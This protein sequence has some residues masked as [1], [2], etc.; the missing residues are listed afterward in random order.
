MRS[1]NQR[2]IRAYVAF[3]AGLALAGFGFVAVVSGMERPPAQA[4]A[5]FTPPGSTGLPP[6]V[7]GTP[8]AS[9]TPIITPPPTSAAPGCDTILP[10]EIGDTVTVRSGISIRFGPSVSAPLLE[11]ILQNRSFTVI[12]GPT[13]SDNYVW[14]N[15][16]SIGLTGWVA[17]R[18][19]N[20]SF[21]VSFSGEEALVCDAPQDLAFGDRIE[22]VRNVRI[23]DAASIDG[24]VLTVAPVDSVVTIQSAAVCVDGYNWRRV[25]VTVLGVVYD[26]WMAEA[27]PDT[28]DAAF[29]IDEGPACYPP[30]GFAPGDLAR[31]YFRSGPPRNL[32]TAPNLEA[33]VINVLF[34]GVPL[35]I[36]D[37][38]VCSGGT[39]W[40]QVQVQG[41]SQRPIG[42][43]AEG[44]RPIP[45]IRPFDAPPLP[46]P[47][48]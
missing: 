45:V 37:G 10:L 21:I 6:G 40:W 33:E 5:T 16:S 38:P 11:T 46:I 34:S 29:F 1:M 14:W 43:L 39:N 8:E 44:G 7:T 25:R 23:R 13:C 26:G 36:L 2:W 31:V 47:G 32:R 12:G 24:L 35:Q 27:E 48:R 42:W 19:A 28:P 4:Q 30:L 18:N 3:L 22:L 41:G 20:I 17:E 15:I 9:A